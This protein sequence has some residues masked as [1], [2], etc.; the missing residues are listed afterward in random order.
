M[1]KSSGKLYT[2][3]ELEALDYHSLDYK[4]FILTSH[5]RQQQNF[6]EEALLGAKT[7]RKKLQK[8]IYLLKNS[9]DSQNLSDLYNQYYNDFTECLAKDLNTAKIIALIWI[10]IKDKNL[11]NYEKITLIQEFDSILNLDL[12]DYTEDN[13]SITDQDK[14]LLNERVEAKKEKNFQRADEIRDY[15]LK[16]G[17]QILDTKEGAFLKKI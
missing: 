1:S 14:S 7:A 10:V 2:L 9:L 17:F 4:Y 3:A 15:F 11:S 8:Q 12:F 6:S 5:Y 16:K 13:I